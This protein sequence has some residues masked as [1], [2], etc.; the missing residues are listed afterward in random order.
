MQVSGQFHSGHLSPQKNRSTH[1]I[2]GVMDPICGLAIF[3]DEKNLLENITVPK[4]MCVFKKM[5]FC[6]VL[7]CF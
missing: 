7:L 1:Y 6:L 5:L 4:Y 3:G 2:R